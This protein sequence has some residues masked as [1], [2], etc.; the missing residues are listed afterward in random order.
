MQHFALYFLD[1]FVHKSFILT[2]QSSFI[3]ETK[4]FTLKELLF[5]FP[6]Y[7][8]KSFRLQTSKRSDGW[9]RR[10]QRQRNAASVP[11]LQAAGPIPGSAHADDLQAPQA[12]NGSSSEELC[13]AGRAPY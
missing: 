9:N 6:A 1:F 2:V 4:P 12:L 11:L 5:L 10:L 7:S 8:R 3:E 13:A